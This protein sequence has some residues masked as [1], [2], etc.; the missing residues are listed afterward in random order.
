[1]LPALYHLLLLLLLCLHSTHAD[2]LDEDCEACGLIVW[3]MQA[4]IAA[5]QEELDGH[6]QAKDKRAQ[7]STKPQSRKWI[8]QEYAVE[9]ASAV[10]TSIN[11]LPKDRKIMEGACR[12]DS[13]AIPG[14]LLRKGNDQYFTGHKCMERVES[15][16]GALIGDYE[17]ELQQA[18]LS[19]LGAGQ[20]CAKVLEACSAKRA[21]LLLGSQYKKEGMSVRELDMLQVG[22][23]DQFTVHT[24]V[25]GSKYWFSRSRMTSQREPPPGWVKNEKHKDGWEYRHDWTLPKEEL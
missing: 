4:I 8:K 11:A 2:R 7:K 17:D 18:V 24:D 20:A 3:R 19:G 5:K 12:P 6:K 23:N 21:L 1:M 10:E 25:D 15:R 22:Y 13:H 9:L 14:S 16:I